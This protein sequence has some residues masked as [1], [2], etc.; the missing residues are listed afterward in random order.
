MADKLKA[1]GNPTKVYFKRKV[2][3][4]LM[5]KM[6]LAGWGSGPEDKAHWEENGW[7][8]KDRPW[9]KRAVANQRTLFKKEG[10]RDNPWHVSKVTVIFYSGQ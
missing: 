4:L 5:R 1:A 6:Q 8:G 10:H 2:M 9:K 7:L 3:F